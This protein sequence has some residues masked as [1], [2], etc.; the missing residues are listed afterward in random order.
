MNWK[1][2]CLAIAVIIF[3][4]SAVI[5][6][7][8]AALSIATTAVPAGQLG[9][10]YSTTISANGGT[11][12]YRWSLDWGTL[13]PGT[14]LNATT[15]VLAGTPS[16]SGTFSFTVKVTDASP[17]PYTAKQVLTLQV[18]GSPLSIATT[19]IP[20]GQLGAA[21]S[22]TIS[23]KGG[24]PPYR[25]SIDWGT[26]PPG[27]SLNAN[28]G[29]LA[30]T[31]SNSGTFSFTVKVTDASPTPY[32]AKQVLTLQVPGSPLS[33][34][35]TAVSAGQLGAAYSTTISPKGGTGPYRWSIDW[36]TLPPG[37]SLN[38][39]TGVLAGTPSQSGTFSFTVKVTDASPTPYTAKQVLTLQ[40]AGSPLSIATATIPNGQLGAAYSTT[41]SPN[42][43]T[44]PYKWSV[45]SGAL[46]S[47]VGLNATTGVLAGT[48]SQSGTFAFSIAAQ[49]SSAVPQ[50]ASKAFSLMVQASLA[51]TAA[52]L[53]TGQKAVQYSQT[54]SASGGVT[55]YTWSVIA[56]SLPAG[57]GLDALTGKITGTPTQ[58]GS[59]SFTVEVQDATGSA[60]NKAT[61]LTIVGA[62]YYLATAADGGSDY[63]NGL[64]PDAPWLTP[65]HPLNCGDTITAEASNSY[66]EA[67]FEYGKWGHVTC[68]SGATANVAWLKCATFDACKLT[69]TNQNGMW[70]TSS[71]W[72]VQGWEVT[73]SGGQ[74]ICFAAYPPTS[75]ANIHHIIFAN[76]I[77][78][79]CYG[80]GFAAV[81]NGSA[82]VDYLALIADIAYDAAQQATEC[83]SGISVNVPS[84][85]DSLP[86]THIYVAGNFTW[87]NFD[88]NPCA[89]GIP[90][91]GEGIIFDT[92]DANSYTAQAVM[93]N[94]ISFLNGNSGF[95]VDATTLAPVFIVNNT[96]FGNNGD[97]A[98]N[99][100]ECGEITL[101]QSNGIQVYNNIARTNSVS[102]C[103]SNPNYAF[104]VASGNST[105]SVNLNLGYAISGQSVGSGGSPEFSYGT[106]NVFGTDPN[107]AS[108]P[109]SNPGPPSCG[110]STSVPNCMAMAIANF[111]PQASAASGLGYQV[112]SVIHTIDALFPGWLCNVNL[113]S[114]LIPNHC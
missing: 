50:V 16:N 64:S 38:A 20:N 23:P 107:F 83:G 66:D 76:D 68:S 46:P 24:T 10:A 35:T 73:A 69:A 54:I 99:S 89:G 32:T 57:L 77:A 6:S 103:G 78:N 67:N 18:P 91:D 30:G 75:S 49:D 52:S 82:G 43:G 90:T 72:G 97:S 56:G 101:Q 37:T 8:T 74:A 51:I 102:G 109:S 58:A 70:V 2:A 40:V 88:P 105:D 39:N 100:G 59:A 21:Y 55:P 60:A 5:V 80:A 98:M 17:T 108:P 110:S 104:Y 87:H 14:S 48:P 41:I 42:S 114:G 86:G 1:K 112:P 81:G 4:T 15:G 93:E 65:N 28:T 85:S 36:G 71:Y 9:A 63:N 27:T 47:G 22:T 61:A 44:G 79:G 111:V 84:Q 13:P 29:V 31:P 7:A 25:W 34:A 113:P 26:L 45:A 53:P 33:I 11:A 95:R 106:G 62:S 12:P 3:A 96:S 92:F 19:A 94:N